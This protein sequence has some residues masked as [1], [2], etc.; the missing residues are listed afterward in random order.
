[1]RFML[2]WSILITGL[3]N[4][5]RPLSA[6]S[7]LPPN[8]LSPYRINRILVEIPPAMS[9]RR[10]S[11][12]GVSYREEKIPLFEGRIPPNRR[13][14]I[15]YV[16]LDDNVRAIEVQ[17]QTEVS[18]SSP[19]QLAV[20]ANPFAVRLFSNI[21]LE[22]YQDLGPG[23][24]VYIDPLGPAFPDAA[25]LLKRGIHL[26]IS[27]DQLQTHEALRDSEAGP[28]EGSVL[29]LQDLETPQDLLETNRARLRDFKKR[30]LSLISARHFYGVSEDS[31]ESLIFTR[32]TPEVMAQSLEQDLPEK[33]GSTI[34]TL[35]LIGFYLGSLLSMLSLR[36]K[37]VLLPLLFLLL[38]MFFLVS[39][40]NPGGDRLL[41]LTL[42][43][44]HT[45]V[46]TIRLE[47]LD[48]SPS[49]RRTE[50][51]FKARDLSAETWQLE[52]RSVRVR[53]KRLRV[54]SLLD[55]EYIKFNQIPLISSDGNDYFVDFRNPLKMWILYESK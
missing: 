6:Q 51:S 18:S 26:M 41:V 52:Y 40:M 3:L 39:I 50:A 46:E 15:A 48:S 49:Y 53:Q 29:V 37:K 11:I 42:N 43:P 54:E 9:Y 20:R 34:V 55:S 33:G 47:R 8:G 5:C 45:Q 27:V 7:A 31:R 32:A 19:L 12:S 13:E 38:V 25:L 10:I 2:V 16:Y 4:L 28:Y 35:S 21:N 44:R 1:M 24:I 17:L 14:I 23:D 22:T 30:F 36:S